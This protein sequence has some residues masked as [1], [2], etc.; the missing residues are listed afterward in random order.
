MKNEETP[1]CQ[2]CGTPLSDPGFRG[3]DKE[4][5][6]VES[7]CIFC[8]KDGTFT[9]PKLTMEQMGWRIHRVLV[10]QASI[11]AREAVS[12]IDGI[13]PKLKRWRQVSG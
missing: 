8:F 13:L 12:M 10:Q 1:I 5:A 2:S 3:T 11:P 4:N 6:R 9:E 7:Y